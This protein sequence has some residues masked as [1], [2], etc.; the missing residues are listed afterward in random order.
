MA[1]GSSAATALIAVNLARAT[2]TAKDDEAR[3]A[4]IRLP[5][6][7]VL[8]ARV[9]HSR[10]RTWEVR[11]T[12]WVPWGGDQDKLRD[13]V[14]LHAQRLVA[15]AAGSPENLGLARAAAEAIVRGFYEEF[16]W[17]VRV[18]W[19]G[20]AA[21]QKPASG[22]AEA[23]STDPHG[24]FDLA[25]IDDRRRGPSS[26]AATNWLTRGPV[27]SM[28]HPGPRLASGPPRAFLADGRDGQDGQDAGSCVRT[29]MDGQD[30]PLII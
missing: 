17:H 8:Q 9:D 5:Q 7:E 6:P 12:T 13:S 4:V 2:I 26:V 27:S 18:T 29:M 28:P 16:G 21:E 10:T 20:E 19:E 1:P 23:A 11:K 14:M 25:A 15:H 30:N 22:A 3:Q 24:R